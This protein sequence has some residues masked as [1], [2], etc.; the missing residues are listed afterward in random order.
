[1]PTTPRA[2]I[3]EWCQVSTF[4]IH[5]YQEAASGSRAFSRARHSA[6]GRI[7]PFR[8]ENHEWTQIDTN[9]KTCGVLAL[10]LTLTT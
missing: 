7:A 2:E 9:K 5:R 1:M 8:M 3:S 10:R 6:P 4:N